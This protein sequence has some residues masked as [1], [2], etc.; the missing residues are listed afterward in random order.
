MAPRRGG[1]PPG[2]QHGVPWP[3]GAAQRL[4]GIADVDDLEA[5][6]PLQHLEHEERVV[7]IVFDHEDPPP[8]RARL[9]RLTW[10]LGAAHR[11]IGRYTLN[12][13]PR[14]S[15]L[16]TS[17]RPPCRS[18]TAFN[19]EKPR[20]GPGRLGAFA[21]EAGGNRSKTWPSGA[22]GM[23]MPESVTSP[24]HARSPCV[25]VMRIS[26]SRC[27]PAAGFLAVNLMA[28]DRRFSNT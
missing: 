22:G 15:A 21:W 26:P 8:G 4:S 27:C 28:L 20:P 6:P 12:V 13:V 25:A 16:S 23:P 24:R 17:T 2:G 14:A 10:P 3:A 11:A 1:A 5:A 18:A 7:W 9:A 19:P